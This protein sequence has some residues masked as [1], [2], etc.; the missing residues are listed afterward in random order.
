MGAVGAAVAATAAAAEKWTDGPRIAGR[1]DARG[2]CVD[3]CRAEKFC[4]RLDRKKKGDW[5]KLCFLSFDRGVGRGEGQG[6]QKEN[7][8]V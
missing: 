2:K 4:R 5:D 6:E 7:I 3:V 8:L 1:K